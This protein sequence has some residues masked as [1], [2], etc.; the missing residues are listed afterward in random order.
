ML[1]DTTCP[2]LDGGHLSFEYCNFV[3]MA[4]GHLSFEYCNF[5]VMAHPPEHLP[6]TDKILATGLGDSLR[7]SP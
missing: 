4:H 7:I 1:C 6:P 5:V 2:V 3:V